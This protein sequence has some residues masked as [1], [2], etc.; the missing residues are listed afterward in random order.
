MSVSYGKLILSLQRGVIIWLEA[1]VA[2]AAV[3]VAVVA[4]VAG[5]HLVEA[6]AVD[7]V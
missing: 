6:V 4:E 2:V 3:V 7:V 5:A 1:V